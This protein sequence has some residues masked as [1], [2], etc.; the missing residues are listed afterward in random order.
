[1][2][3]ESR[4]ATSAPGFG[5]ETG[6]PTDAAHTAEVGVT[7]VTQFFH[8]DTSANAAILTELATGLADRGLDVSVVTAQPSYAEADRDAREPRRET[9][10]GVDVTRVPSTRFDKNAG[11]SRRLANELTFAASASVRTLLDGG[12]DPLLLPT[13]PPFLPIVGWGLSAITDRPTVP[14]VFDLYPHM[15]A[16]LG[17][18]SADG[19]VYRLWNRLNSRAYGSADRVITI[20]ETMA[21]TLSRNYGEDCD[22]T[23]IPNWED[24]AYIRPKDKAENPFSRQHDLV[25]RT[26][27]LYSGNLGHHHDLES[28]VEAAATLEETHDADE[29]AFVLIGEGGQ[30]ER[31]QTLAERRGL[32]TVTFLPYQ[33]REALPNSLTCGDVALV[34]MR[35][36][37]EGL[38]V[39]SKFYTALASGQAVL[40]IASANSEIGRI[41][42]RTDVGRRVDPGSPD[43]LAAAIEAFVDDPEGTARMGRAARELF[44]A[45]YTA[46][47]AIDRYRDVI[48]DVARGAD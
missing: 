43:E 44:E 16:E 2:A 27:V 8:P 4:S 23:V 9:Y 7:M 11:V 45:E 37:V 47:R 26:T 15:A 17:Y 31:L 18:L 21:E 38:C 41:V 33:P 32:E 20:G 19:L 5:T 28:V 12:D 46:D 30:K 39:S 6:T 40:A 34:S 10:R 22:V 42:D 13:A 3:R 48:V 25:D 14:V 35:A 29:L 1:M 36:G 24:G